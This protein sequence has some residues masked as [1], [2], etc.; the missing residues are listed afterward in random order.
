MTPHKRLLILF[1]V[2]ICSS[3]STT[4]FLAPGQKLYDGAKINITD[5]NT[6][7]GEAGDLKDEME[8]LVRPK[9]NGK[10][11]GLR[12]KLWVYF[13][14]RTNKKK[15]LRH[16]LNTHM[17]E[18]PVL[19]SS[20]DVDKN[21]QIMKNRLQNE[22]YFLAQAVGDT[23]SKKQIAKAIYTIQTGPSYHYNQITFPN[24]K[25]DVDTAVAGTSPQTLLKV[26]D[27]FNLDI[28]KAERIRID[29]RLKEEGF[30]YFAP[31]DLLM[32]YD[33]TVAGHKVN[34]FVTVKP[35]TPDEATW[36][37]KIR[38]IYLYPHY[39]IKD[40]SLKLDSAVKYRWYNVIDPAN[41][42]KPYVFKNSVLLHP[43]DIYNRTEHNNSLS[44]FMQL[45]P[46]RFVKN[47]FEDVTPD[48]A[49]LDIYYF[50]TQQKRKSLQFDIE[51]HQTSSN[52]DGTQL[53]FNFK[54]RN[55]FK[56][57]ELYNITFFASRD[58]QFGKYNAGYNVYQFGVQPSLT[59][60]RFVSPFNF[61][62]DNAFI[63]KTIL[64]VGYTLI[65]RTKLY[66]LNSFSFSWGY[67]WKP[68]LH[69][70]HTLDLLDLTYVN[71]ANVTKIYTDSIAKTR[72]P[73]LAH[74]IDKQFTFGPSYSYIYTNT[75]ET[76]KVNT[77]YYD[78][79]IS[80]SGNLV[81]ILSGADTLHGKVSKLFNTPFDQ[82]VK[83]ENEFR[84]YHKLGKN[85]KLATRVMFDIGLPYGNSTILP[86]SQ[87]FFI[88]GANS[89]RGFQAH[90]VGP[91]TYIIPEELTHGTNFLPDESGD[92]KIEANVE[93]R[94]KLFSVVNG[95]LFMDAGNIW[96][97]KSH[98][99]LPGA[100]FSS[101]FLNQM[102]VDW[103]FGLRFDFTVLLLRTDMGFPVRYPFPPG[104]PYRFNLH[105][106]VFNLAI[107]Y[108]F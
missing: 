10:I 57:A 95:A 53:N 66:N 52:Y 8:S 58:I 49:Y 33:S 41:T 68:S 70:Q 16:Y 91:G 72:N 61:K 31:E 106:P 50:L 12:F 29:A 100:T 55:M 80:L 101:H 94:A 108:P 85:S 98:A 28:I 14:T 77:Y 34:L 86:Y 15:G 40:T 1:I 88:G 104:Q 17:G 48:S 43:G 74:V 92:I 90:S 71:S 59:W 37:Y 69:K 18:P 83:F 75:T 23:T 51:E 81:G 6:T 99:D 65:D 4:K 47:R 38:N 26:G 42:I 64:S 7:K 87:Q 35:E 36:I 3:C 56:G 103:G 63:P 21:A 25:D 2:L 84:F 27:K 11:L 76:Q 60:P 45:G 73:S 96:N 79:K 97:T 5:K 20:V 82:Y 89:L 24:I 102:A 107:G 62:T 67:Q 44:R 32:K 105:S 78:G 19:I 93:Y 54:N 46:F 13:K 22:S 39:T 30:Y 9:P